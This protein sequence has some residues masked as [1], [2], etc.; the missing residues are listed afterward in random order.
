[1]RAN[2][3][4][5]GAGKSLSAEWFAYLFFPMNLSIKLLKSC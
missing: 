5:S 4:E 3:R 2:Q 1:M